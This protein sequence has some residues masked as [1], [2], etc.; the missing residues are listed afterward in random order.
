MEKL[1]ISFL[2]VLV[3]TQ[4]NAKKTFDWTMPEG[5]LINVFVCEKDKKKLNWSEFILAVNTNTCS[6]KPKVE[7][8]N[9]CF[10][11]QG[12]GRLNEGKS[13]FFRLTT[14]CL[15]E[16]SSMAPTSYVNICI[17]RERK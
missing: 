7:I 5:E 3:C 15:L 13:P 2:A 14:R 12:I 4:L 17:P 10:G 16:N 6:M 9:M 11:S 8:K 1:M